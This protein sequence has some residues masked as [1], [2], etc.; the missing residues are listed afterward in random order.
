MDASHVVTSR[1]SARCRLDGMLRI[2]TSPGQHTIQEGD[3][4]TV[5]FAGGFRLVLTSP[6]CYHPR[7][8]NPE[9]GLGAPTYDLAGYAEWTGRIL[10]RAAA[11]L[12]PDGSLCIVKTDVRYRGAILPVGFAL[13]MWLVDHGLSLSAH[14]IWERFPQYSPY[15]PSIA[16]VFVFGREVGA[17]LRFPT[18]IRDCPVRRLRGLPS[19][20]TPE[21]FRVLIERLTAPGDLVLDPFLGCGSVLLAAHCTGRW[22]AGIEMSP[23]QIRR[24]ASVLADVPGV[25]YNSRPKPRVNHG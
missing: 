24:A 9:H 25:R 18:V 11:A 17:P 12:D 10:L 13:A 3:S 14:W 8:Q 4:S 23:E 7:R 5:E 1:R 15:A 19:S 16:N 20:F 2:A 6:P 21:I 22:A